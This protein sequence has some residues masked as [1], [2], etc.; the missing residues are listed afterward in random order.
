[1]MGESGSPQGESTPRDQ[2]TQGEQPGCEIEGLQELHAAAGKLLAALASKP[3]ENRD[4]RRA[5]FAAYEAHRNLATPR[6]WP[7]NLFYLLFLAATAASPFYVASLEPSARVVAWDIFA[8]TSTMVLLYLTYGFYTVKTVLGWIGAMIPWRPKFM[9]KRRKDATCARE[10]SQGDGRNAL[11]SGAAVILLGIGTLLALNAWSDLE[12]IYKL[13]VD[14]NEPSMLSQYYWHYFTLV[15]WLSILFIFMD[16]TVASFNDSHS[17]TF[18]AASSFAYVTVP[19]AIGIFLVGTYLWKEY[20]YASAHGV[21]P[22]ASMS[23]E[24][25]SGALA[26]QMIVSNVLFI[27]IKKNTAIRSLYWT[28]HSTKRC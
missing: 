22:W 3:P 5:A 23:V 25:A 13:S 8:I 24:F 20:D 2:A 11:E 28:I 9:K 26:F 1:M 21:D 12:L 17:E 4:E 14:G 19:M 10:V 15:F 27:M 18:I 16:W 7:A 6:S